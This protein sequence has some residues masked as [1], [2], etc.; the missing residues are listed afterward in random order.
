VEDVHWA[1]AAL[2][3]L[4]EHLAD[5]LAETRVLVLCTARP[6]FLD[7]RPTWGAG[8][9]NATSLTLAPLSSDESARLVSS[10]LGEAQMSESGASR[11]SRLRAENPSGSSPWPRPSSRGFCEGPYGARHRGVGRRVEAPLPCSGP[12]R[13]ARIRLRLRARE[14][15]CARVRLDLA[16]ALE[17]AGETA[18]AAEK[19]HEAETHFTAIGCVN[20]V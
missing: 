1:S 9:Q 15:D 7:R 2:L 14:A 3:D 12:P 20:R 5:T 16:H 4:V 18:A 11:R 19:R 10:L 17:Q 6:E 13:R 8:K